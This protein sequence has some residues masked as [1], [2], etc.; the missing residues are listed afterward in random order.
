[1]VG[2]LAFPPRGYPTNP[3]PE[4]PSTPLE[5]EQEPLPHP[6]LD[7]M[8]EERRQQDAERRRCRLE[9]LHGKIHWVHMGSS[10]RD[11]YGHKD[12][13]RTKE[14]RILS[15]IPDGERRAVERWTEYETRWR[16][17]VSSA[18]PVAFQDVP[19][20]VT[21]WARSPSDLAPE[22]ISEFFLA[23]L[24]VAVN[25]VSRKCRIR[26]CIL[27]WHP[28]KLSAVI[29]RTVQEDVDDVRWGINTVFHVL[30]FIK[31]LDH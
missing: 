5:V 28:D 9:A 22:T 10:I 1:M 23:P 7:R 14:L 11:Q 16:V 4:A 15:N 25:T 8:R 29:A 13:A 2:Y 27:R 12:R 19:W 20:P 26:A 31:D 24:R 3:P 6:D 30:K 17:L 21:P 18:Y